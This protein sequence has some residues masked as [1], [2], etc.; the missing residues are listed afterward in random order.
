MFDLLVAGRGSVVGTVDL[1]TVQL[2]AWVAQRRRRV[3]W[4]RAVGNHLLSQLDR[5]FP[6]ASGCCH[7][8]LGTGVGRLIVAEF[9]DP[10]R[11]AC[12][13]VQ[14]FRRFAANRGIRVTTGKASAFVCAAQQALPA[15]DASVARAAVASDLRLLHELERQIAGA[16]EQLGRLLPS[17]PFAVLTTTPGWAT[18]RAALY[19]AAVGDI[20]RWPSADKVYR[21]SG[22][23]PTVHESAGRRRDGGISREGSVSLRHALLELA[24]G[25]RHHEPAARGYAARLAG[26]GKHSM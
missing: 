21:A 3:E 2:A 24:Q 26:R 14:R 12:L 10:G 7:Q 11:L 17:T 15:A 6:G 16:D 9:T 1:A 13:G 20:A 5:A 19:G 22:L 4:K 8:L 23:T 18:I 25:L